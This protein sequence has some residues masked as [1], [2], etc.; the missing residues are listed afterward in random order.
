M[1][2]GRGNDVFIVDN[3]QD[4][5]YESRSQG[6]DTVKS[7]VS[8]SLSGTHVE[9][10]Y[11]DGAANIN[12][13]GNS[14]DN[15]LYGNAGKNVLK[16][17]S[18][19]DILRGYA[20]NDKLYGG[21]GNDKLYGGA[22]DDWLYGGPGQDMFVFERSSGRDRIKDFQVGLDKIDVRAWSNVHDLADLKMTQSGAH[23]VIH[24]GADVVVVEHVQLAALSLRD[25]LL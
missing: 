25:F 19:N 15:R 17:S 14:L 16:A 1:W 5:T 10:L 24:H 8:Y 11:L 20:G 18:G 22:G 3:R 7:S 21:S 12:G 2:G 4:R 23:V 6:T 9:R 13:T